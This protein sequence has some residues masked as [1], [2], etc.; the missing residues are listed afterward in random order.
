LRVAPAEEMFYNVDEKF[1]QKYE[2]DENLLRMKMFSK[3]DVNGL[4]FEGGP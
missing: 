3:T 4:Q 2:A 1:D